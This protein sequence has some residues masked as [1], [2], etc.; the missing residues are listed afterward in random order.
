MKEAVLYEKLKGNLVKCNL[1]NHHCVIADKKRGICGV[2]ENQNG[3]LYALNYGKVIASNIDPIEK[4]PFFHFLPGS[5]AFSI[6]TV[7]CNFRCKNCQNWEI[8]QRACEMEHIPGEEISPEEVVDLAQKYDCRNIAYTYTEPTI[9]FEYAYDVSKIAKKKKIKNNFVTNGYMTKEAL[10]LI[11]NYLDAAN[12]DIKGSDKFY[13]EISSARLEF[14]LQT[15]KEMKKKGIWVEITTLIIPTLS[16]L[17]EDL[18]Q[19]AEFI[20]DLGVE[21]PWHISRFHPDYLLTDIPSTP[22]QSIE[23]ARKIGLDAGLRY[24]YAGNIPGSPWENT[25]C[26]NCG[27][28]LIRRHGFDVIENK[29]ID[30]KCFNCGSKIDGVFK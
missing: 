20:R 11:G 14:V 7:G 4:K 19:I 9:F 8:S 30:S 5:K 29:I 18:K 22:L 13:R 23:K 21:I 6:S 3:V 27:E 16:D 1:C 28:L 25:Y 26:Y 24:V 12:V 2:R 17:E 15:I 10:D